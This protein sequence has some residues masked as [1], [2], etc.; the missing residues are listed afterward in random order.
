MSESLE[1]IQH[2]AC[3]RRDETGDHDTALHDRDA[4]ARCRHHDI[5]LGPAAQLPDVDP[6]VFLHPITVAA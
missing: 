2:R 4:Y 6:L 5:V 3:F 1:P